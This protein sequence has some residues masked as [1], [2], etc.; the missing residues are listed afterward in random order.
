MNPDT[1]NSSFTVRRIRKTSP[2]VNVTILEDLPLSEVCEAFEGFLLALG[3]SF[4]E[5]AH[6]GFEYDDTNIPTE[7]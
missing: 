3:F 6:L 4:P 7:E 5:G 1:N 2:Q